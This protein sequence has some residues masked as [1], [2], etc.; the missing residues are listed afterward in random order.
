MNRYRY[1]ATSIL[2]GRVLMDDI[3][4]VVRSAT[5]SICGIGRLDGYLSLSSQSAPATSAFLRA[6]IPGQTMLWVLQSGY[7]IWC[8]PLMDS[9]HTSILTH[10]YPITAY[11]PE[12][13]LQWRLIQTALTYTGMDVFDILRAII[14]YGTTG[15]A[16]APNAGIAGLV[17]GALESGFTDTLTLGV[18]NTLTA[19]GNVYSGTYADEQSCWDAATTLAAADEFEF[20]LSPQLAGTTLQIGLQLGRPAIGQYNTPRMQLTFPGQVIDYAR[21]IMRSQAGNYI[22]G[23]SASNGTG[24]TYTSQ[25]PHGVDTNDLGQGNIL[26]QKA[27]TWSGVGVTSQA[28]I[29][30]YVDTLIAPN[31]AGTMVPQI[32]LGGGQIPSLTQ[33]GLGDAVRFAATSDLDPPGAGGAPGLQVTARVTGW[34]LQPPASRQPEKLTLSLGAL[35]GSTGIGGVGIP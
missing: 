21:P 14:T 16:E 3:P 9:P 13:I 24:T 4:L 20:A 6:L 7:P 34:A 25:Y 2:S 29:N 15:G 30:Q 8:G 19:G 26:Q 22:I 33:I 1:V 28:Q 10:Q 18:S 32:V 11:T 23:T 35:V 12:A 27:V 5:R 31:T 17:L